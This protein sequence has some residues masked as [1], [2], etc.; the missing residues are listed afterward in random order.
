MLATVRTD[1]GRYGID[2]LQI[3][4]RVIFSRRVLR[5]MPSNGPG[6]KR[7]GEVEAELA[8]VGQWA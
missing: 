7:W 5:P 4:N 3:R 2:T 1:G 8:D 6:D